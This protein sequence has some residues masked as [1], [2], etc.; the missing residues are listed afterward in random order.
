MNEFERKDIIHFKFDFHK[1][2]WLR[3]QL[4]R[5]NIDVTGVMRKRIMIFKY[6]ALACQLLYIN[7]GK[8][9]FGF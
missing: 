9:G 6:N 1:K 4:L 3:N 5:Y 7:T 8:P 2:I